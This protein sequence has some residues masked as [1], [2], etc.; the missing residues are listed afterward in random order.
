MA[1]S[2]TGTPSIIKYSRKI[3][4][5][6]NN[7]GASNLE[8]STSAG[9]AAA[10]SALVLACALFEAADNF[11]AQIDRIEPDGPEDPGPG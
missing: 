2:R 11:P 9:F 1:G 4:R 6:V 3:C 7:Y 5:L 8:A 10:V